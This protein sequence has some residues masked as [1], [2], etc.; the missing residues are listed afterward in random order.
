M[1]AEFD[2]EHNDLP[3]VSEVPV[4]PYRSQSRHPPASYAL[5]LT[6]RGDHLA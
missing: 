3:G 6:E 4:R 5:T 1:N 2:A